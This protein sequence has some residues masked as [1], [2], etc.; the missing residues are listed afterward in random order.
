MAGAAAHRFSPALLHIIVKEGNPAAVQGSKDGENNSGHGQRVAVNAG[1]RSPRQLLQHQNI[2]AAQQSIGQVLENQGDAQRQ[3]QLP[4]VL[5]V[6]Y[7]SLCQN[8]DAP[9]RSH[10]KIADHAAQHTPIIAL[11]H[12]HIQHQQQ[13]YAEICHRHEDAQQHILIG[14]KFIGEFAAEKI[15][16]KDAKCIHENQQQRQPLHL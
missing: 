13:G 10:G 14:L 2:A 4:I 8:P 5:P 12:G 16:S 7:L 11:L 6:R 1:C 15:H 3:A 9:H